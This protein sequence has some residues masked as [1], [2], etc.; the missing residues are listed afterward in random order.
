MKILVRITLGISLLFCSLTGYAASGSVAESDVRYSASLFV[1]LTT[2]RG[3]EEV[4]NQ[5]ADQFQPMDD[6]SSNFGFSRAA[7][8][9]ALELE[10]LDNQDQAIIIRQDYPLID[11]VDMWTQ[12]P[13]GWQQRSTGDRRPF[14]ERDVDHRDFLFPLTL[15]SGEKT[16]VYLRFVSDGALNISLSLSTPSSMLEQISL[17]QLLYGG[18]FGGFFVLIIYNLIIF[19]VVRDKAYFF[20]MMYVLSLGTYMGVSNGLAY[21]YFWPNNPWF[22]NQGL[23]FFLGVSV[24]FG[25]HF[26]RTM[27]NIREYAP[28]FDLFTR[29]LLVVS[30]VLLVASPFL[31]Y[32]LLILPFSFNTLLVAAAMLILGFISMFRG[33]K[34]ARYF[35]VAWAAFLLGVIVYLLKSFGVLEHNVITHNAQQIGSL[36]EMV[37]LSLALSARVNEIK[38]ASH[39]DPLTSLANRRVLDGVFPVEFANAQKHGSPLS[40][41]VLDIDNFKKFNDRLGHVVGDEVIERVGRLLREQV[42]KPHLPCRYGGEEFVVVLPNCDAEEAEQLAE[43]LRQQVE[44]RST[45]TLPVT[46]SIGVATFTGAEFSHHQAMF[47]AADSALYDAKRAGR[48]CV[49][50]AV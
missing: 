8:W 18:Y 27:C 3:F 49:R 35:V 48:N 39:S 40:L 41:L 19:L 23:L 10:N 6:L 50:R 12:T 15:N 29:M 28:R 44:N 31:S 14:A 36:I 43:R 22:A 45:Y 5:F 7:Y 47:E 25:L 2:E 33:S 24:I 16:T 13:Q 37:L 1:D 26:S 4:H 17:E 46:V 11:Y 32:K 34:A 9:V 21:Q 42:R 30:V 20:Y 38:E